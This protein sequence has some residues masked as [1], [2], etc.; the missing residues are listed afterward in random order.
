MF[1]FL[2]LTHL[3]I[4]LVIVWAIIAIASIVIEFE[5]ANLVSIWFAA[6]GIAGIICVILEQAI[7]VQIVAFVIVSAI[8]VVGTRPFVKKISANQTILTNAD[9]YVGMIATVTKSIK[10]GEKGEVKVEFQ[11]WPAIAKNSD[12]TFEVGEK[13]LISNISGNKLIVDKIKEIELD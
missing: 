4:S 13:C 6:G 2:T 1:N 11:L 7:W 5:T 8:F 3:D 10:E 12:F 9:R